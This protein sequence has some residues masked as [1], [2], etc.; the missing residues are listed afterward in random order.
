[1]DNN[2]EEPRKIGT[3]LPA[4]RKKQNN[5]IATERLKHEK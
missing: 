3:C 1:M 2:Q 4:G 5:K